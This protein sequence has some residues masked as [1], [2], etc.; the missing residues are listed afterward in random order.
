MEN[1]KFGKT[2]LFVEV[3]HERKN[4]LFG[5]GLL[6]FFLFPVTLRYWT[7]CLTLN[8]WRRWFETLPAFDFSFRFRWRLCFG[9]CFAQDRYISCATLII[10]GEKGDVKWYF[11]IT[12]NTITLVTQ[13]IIVRHVSPDN[14]S[15]R[16]LDGSDG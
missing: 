13:F 8:S 11:Q 15:W 5:W 4:I 12:L 3:L 9:T 7:M 2:A 14:V 10:F 6:C 1:M 16:K